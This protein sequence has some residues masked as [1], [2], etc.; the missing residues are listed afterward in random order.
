MSTGKKVLSIVLSI[1]FLIPTAALPSSAAGNVAPIVY[2]YGYQGVYVFNEDGTYYTPI[3][4]NKAPPET[5][6][7]D[8][9]SAAVSELTPVFAKA[10]V[11]DN[12]D[13]YCD[14]AFELLAPIYAEV[15]PNPDGTVPENTGRLW[16]WSY[17]ELEAHPDQDT[18]YGF[19]WDTRLSPL[20]AADELNEYIGAIQKKTGCRQ[21][22]LVSR[23]IG[24]EAVSSYLWKYQKD[25]GCKD[26][27]KCIFI[28]NSL[29]GYDFFDV[30]LSGNITGAADAL[31]R[32]VKQNEIL[33]N[34]ISNN[35]LLQFAEGMFGYLET[36]YGLKMAMPM[37]EHIYGKI[38]DRLIARLLK[39][40]YGISLGEVG[41]I[42]DHYEAY[43][44]YIFQ[45]EGDREK[46]AAIIADADDYHYN[47]Q[48]NVHGMLQE[49]NDAGTPVCFIGGYGEQ[50]YPLGDFADYIGDEY[51]PLSATTFGATI[52]KMTKKLPA[53]YIADRK[54][55]GYEAYLSP[56]LQVDASTCQFPD[57]TWVVKNLRHTFGGDDLTELIRAIARTDGAT[58]TTV[59]GYPQFLNVKADHSAMEPATA[60]N[61]NDVDWTALEPTL[62]SPVNA[63]AQLNAFFAKIILRLKALFDSFSAVF[64]FA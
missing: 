14:R 52:A 6:D 43:K 18:I 57:Q 2:V 19:S 55:A 35:M 38:K 40:F 56:D 13:E 62:S 20:K 32:Y 49:I 58:V 47:V 60:V 26:V 45:E 24:T 59:E 8:I 64:N 17:D 29:D 12:Y 28:A 51:A 10:I 4:A 21:V 50:Q 37:A 61:D 16:Q 3:D 22:T 11:T 63:L 36:S 31:Y 5:T 46:Y 34:N 7:S 41:T 25:A 44:D 1:L 30:L 23:C 53:D 33:E 42:N 9:V 27:R 15:K 54:A 39:E 48:V